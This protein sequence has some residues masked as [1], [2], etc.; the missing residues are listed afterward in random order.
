LNILASS[1]I[2][3]FFAVTTAFGAMPAG[4]QV[5]VDSWQPAVGDRFVVDTKSNEGFL[6]HT[7]GRY[8]RFDV[9]TG[10]QKWVYYIGRHYN[11]KTP[12]WDWTVKSKDIKGD[13][14]TFGPSGRFLRLY[15]DGEERTAYGIHEY[16]YEEEMFEK[17]DDRFQSMG[18]V[19][20]RTDMM[21]ILDATFALNEEEGMQVF[22]RY[23]IDAPIKLA[24]NQ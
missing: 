16:G 1:I 11:A 10:Q 14:I 2:G 24:F 12:T 17:R 9:V 5:S 15:K 20:V 21:D 18:C 13:R 8:L 22:T 3:S 4:H 23:G 19:I 7:D 6:I